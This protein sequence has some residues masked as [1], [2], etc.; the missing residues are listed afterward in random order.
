MVEPCE[1]AKEEFVLRILS[2]GAWYPSIVKLAG[3]FNVQ[4]VFA[5]TL[6]SIKIREGNSSLILVITRVRKGSRET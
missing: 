1:S 2:L 6:V 4:S 3:A 5:E